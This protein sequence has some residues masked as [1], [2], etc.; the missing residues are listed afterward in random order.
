MYCVHIMYPR[1]PGSDFDYDHYFRTHLTMGLG[2]FRKHMGFLPKQVFVQKACYGPDRTEA[3][4]DYHAICTLMFE[5]KADADKFIE[6]FEIDEA[7]NLLRA[8]WPKYTEMDPRVVVGE[9]I[10][11]DV[12]RFAEKGQSVIEEA[13]AG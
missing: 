1:K 2:L 4:A 6:L 11:T 7:A 8:D 13:L 9:V 3:S 5:S 12:E 10:E